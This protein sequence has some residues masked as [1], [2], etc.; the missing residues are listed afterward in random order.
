MKGLAFVICAFALAGCASKKGGEFAAD[1]TGKS[2]IHSV[3]S[4]ASISGSVVG[5]SAVKGELSSGDEFI[6]LGSAKSA[7]DVYQ[8][9]ASGG[10]HRI[11]LKTYCDCL[12][13]SKDMIQPDIRVYDKNNNQISVS[14]VNLNRVQP[15]LGALYIDYIYEFNVQ[16]SGDLKVIVASKNDRLGTEVV[17]TETA[18]EI[19]FGTPFSMTIVAAPYGTYDIAIK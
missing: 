16:S 10:S 6:S 2:R 1:A 9:K 19:I 7:F 5:A 8:F 15:T 18:T 17:R 12:G 11:N 13:F 3:N 14:L 4:I